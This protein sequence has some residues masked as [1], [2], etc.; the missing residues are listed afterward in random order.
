MIPRYLLL[1]RVKLPHTKPNYVLKAKVISSGLTKVVTRVKK[2]EYRIENGKPVADLN[3]YV[4]DMNTLI[5]LVRSEIGRSEIVEAERVNHAFATRVCRLKKRIRKMIMS[6]SCIFITLTFRDDVLNN[7]SV[8]TRHD[9]IKRFLNSLHCEY[10]ANIDYGSQNE[11]EHYHALVR[12]DK[13]DPKSYSLGA[14]NF[15]KVVATS[16]SGKLANYI[17]KL[18][19]H[20]IKNSTRGCNIMYSRLK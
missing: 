3:T 6:G 12:C 8:Q 18:T 1:P 13:V 11:R 15:K 17:S 2:N 20:A 16:D 14:I 19:N 4:E 5:G 10:V 7:T 9:Y